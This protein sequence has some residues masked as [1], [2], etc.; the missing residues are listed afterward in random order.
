MPTKVKNLTLQLKLSCNLMSF[1]F[2]TYRYW[3][4]HWDKVFGSFKDRFMGEGGS[5]LILHTLKYYDQVPNR[6]LF[7]VINKYT[8]LIWPTC[9]KLTVMSLEQYYHCSSIFIANCEHISHLSLVFLWLWTGIDWLF[10]KIYVRIIGKFNKTDAIIIIH[11]YKSIQ[12]IIITWII[13]YLWCLVINF[14]EFLTAAI[15]GEYSF[16]ILQRLASTSNWEC[17]ASKTEHILYYY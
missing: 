15:F 10:N 2:T 11:I 1:N 17:I 6:Y 8:G 14:L 3:D 4:I 16:S 9:S 7:K 12:L 5:S 13:G